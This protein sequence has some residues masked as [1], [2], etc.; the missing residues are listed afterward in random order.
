MADFYV[1]P[2]RPILGE[3]I[4][5]VVR[6]YLPGLHVTA[7]DCVRFLEGIAERTNGRA[8]LVHREDLPEGHDVAAAIHDGFGA[9]PD[10]RIVQ[11]TIRGAMPTVLHGPMSG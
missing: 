5:Q 10:D 6:A 11:V 8:F 3:Q 2:P 1:L 4:A 9:G 7:S